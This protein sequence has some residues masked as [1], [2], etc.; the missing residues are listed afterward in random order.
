MAALTSETFNRLF[1]N[2]KS[3]C[4]FDV[5]TGGPPDAGIRPNQIFA[6]SLPHTMLDPARANRVLDVVQEQLLT[7]FGLRTLAPS[8]PQY[9]G[10][11]TGDQASRDGAKIG[12]REFF[13]V[14]AHNH[15]RPARSSS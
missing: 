6:V 7:P 10:R 2:E 9:R 8:D 13:L 5:V 1:W 14:L 12:N 15:D 4:L 3:R 11:Y